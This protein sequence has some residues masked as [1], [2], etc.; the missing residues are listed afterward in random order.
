M[1]ARLLGMVMVDV[2]EL[3]L[4]DRLGEFLR[5][6]NRSRWLGMP[7]LSDVAYLARRPGSKS[8]DRRVTS[9]GMQAKDARTLRLL[10]CSFRMRCDGGGA[11]FGCDVTEAF[12][13]RREVEELKWQL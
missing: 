8:Y 10:L 2:W 9:S 11:P 12:S 5:H 13:G 7:R 4:R 3:S 6:E 1:L